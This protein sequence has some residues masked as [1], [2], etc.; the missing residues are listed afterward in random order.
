M[1]KVPWRRTRII[2]YSH[3]ILRITLITFYNHILENNTY[4]FPCPWFLV[5]MAMLFWIVT[6]IPFCGHAQPGL[7]LSFGSYSEEHLEAAKVRQVFERCEA[8]GDSTDT[9]SRV[10]DLEPKAVTVDKNNMA[11][12]VFQVRT[13]AGVCV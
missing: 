9:S 11:Y 4:Y 10:Q 6:L 1:A 3:G 13:D 7:N 5:S 8:A 12:I 2:L